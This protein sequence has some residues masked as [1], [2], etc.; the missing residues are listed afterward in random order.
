MPL[1]NPGFDPPRPAGAAIPRDGFRSSTPATSRTPSCSTPASRAAGR[2]ACASTTSA[3]NPTAR[4]RSRSKPRH[5]PAR[6]RGSPAGCE[7]RDANETGAVLT[8]LALANGAPARQNFMTEKP[9]KGTTRLDAL[10]DHAS[11]SEGRRAHRDRRDD[12]GQGLPLARRCRARVRQSVTAGLTCRYALRLRP[13]RAGCVGCRG[14]CHALV[15]YDVPARTSAEAAAVLGCAVGQ[16]AKSLI[17]RA[18]SGAPVLVIASGAHRVDEAKVTASPASPSARRM[19]TSCAPSPATRSAAFLR[20]PTRRRCARSSTGISCSTRLFTLLAGRR[21]RCSRS[22]R[23]SSCGWHRRC[24]GG[25]G[26][27]A[28]FAK[29]A[30]W[31]AARSCLPRPP[32]SPAAASR[33]AAPRVRP[34]PRR[35]CASAIAGSTTAPTAFGFR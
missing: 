8:L 21:T 29:E 35:R 27:A 16:I 17:F 15:E 10:H 3:R 18:A 11:D 2:A 7:T 24:R 32:C 19:P 14:R 4:S 34:R 6:S 5:T 25:H 33:S 26:A 13:A 12:A 1:I 23:P 20:S 30:S 28:G 9:V 31:I 22:R